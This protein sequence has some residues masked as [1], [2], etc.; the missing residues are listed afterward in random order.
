MA[1]VQM[2]STTEA[3]PTQL[4]SI[5]CATGQS[6]INHF[7]SGISPLERPGCSGC[8]VGYVGVL[9]ATGPCTRLPVDSMF[10]N[11]CID[12]KCSAYVKY[13]STFICQN[14]SCKIVVHCVSVSGKQSWVCKVQLSYGNSS[15]IQ[16]YWHIWHMQK[17][18]WSIHIYLNIINMLMD[19]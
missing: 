17:H 2:G 14:N 19:Y 5:R 4:K 15:D 9:C 11:K 3:H 1:N 7:Q 10:W 18:L 13:V 6:Q 12:H 8:C 16:M